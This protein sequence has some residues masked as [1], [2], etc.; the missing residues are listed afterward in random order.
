MEMGTE[1]ASQPEIRPNHSVKRDRPQATLVVSL[2]GFA[3]TVTFHVKHL[4]SKN[5]TVRSGLRIQP[6]DATAC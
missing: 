4:L 3:A 2:R 6:V 1:C 5:L